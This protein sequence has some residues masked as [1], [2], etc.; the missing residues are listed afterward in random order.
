MRKAAWVAVAV[1]SA[2]AQGAVFRCLDASGVTTYSDKPCA[3]PPPVATPI[4]PNPAANPRE[5]QARQILLMLRLMSG[6]GGDAT[7]DPQFIESI[8]PD[9]VRGLDP[10]NG[11]WNPQNARWH[12]M[13][14]FVKADLRRDLPVALKSSD[15]RALQ[16]AAREYAARAQDSDLAALLQYLNSDKGGRYIAFQNVVRLITAQTVR[17]LLAQEPIVAAPA[18]EAVFRQRQQVLSLSLEARLVADGGG[19]YGPNFEGAPG[20]LDNAAHREG[21]ALD[22]LLAEYG[23][24]IPGFVAFTQSLTARRFF[25]AIEPAYHTGHLMAVT[26]APAFA[27]V[28][29]QKYAERWQ[30]QYGPKIRIATRVVVVGNRYTGVT[31]TNVTSN[32]VSPTSSNRNVAAE[33]MATQCEQRESNAYLARSRAVDPATRS[34]D[35]KQIQNRCRAEQNL[36]PF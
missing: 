15:D 36:P 23:S 7:G 34:I 20:V 5:A 12:Y 25:A 26:A 18:T 9:L 32:Y 13:L 21:T 17:D 3:P 6:P 30:A 10:D 35:L 28:E 1:L 8:A 19:N 29:M 33:G 16:E 14:E 24:D 11:A 22:A 31:V 4:A 2:S 27:E